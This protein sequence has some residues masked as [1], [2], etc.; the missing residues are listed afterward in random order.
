M[1]LAPVLFSG[2][3]DAPFVLADVIVIFV[4]GLIRFIKEFTTDDQT[5]TLPDSRRGD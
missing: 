3:T 1:I 5:R 4:T 2:L